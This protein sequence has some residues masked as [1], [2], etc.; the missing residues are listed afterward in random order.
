MLLG[1]NNDNS[2]LIF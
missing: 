1:K 2:F